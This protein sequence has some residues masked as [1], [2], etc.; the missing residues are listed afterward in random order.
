M[1]K[2]ESYETADFGCIP[3]EQVEGESLLVRKGRKGDTAGSRSCITASQQ[4][5]DFE[6]FM[7][8]CVCVC[9]CVILR[10]IASAIKELL[11]TVNTV[12]RKYQHHNRR[13]S[14]RMKK[15]KC[16]PTNVVSV[17]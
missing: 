16:I 15:M 14:R 13:V 9:V 2:N 5:T 7:H 8:L 4:Q 10:D 1:L 17:K 11:D 12:F 3:G 6:I